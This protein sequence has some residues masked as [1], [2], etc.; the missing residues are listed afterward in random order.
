MCESTTSPC[1]PNIE[2][3]RRRNR[4]SALRC[5]AKKKLKQ[6]ALLER[7]EQI[8]AENNMLKEENQRLRKQLAFQIADSFNYEHFFV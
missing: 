8:K 4:E 5:R 6:Q 2:N 1:P 7:F 3:R